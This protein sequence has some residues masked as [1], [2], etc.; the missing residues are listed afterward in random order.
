MINHGIDGN[1]LFLDSQD[2]AR[3]VHNLYEFNDTEQTENLHRLFDPKM[4]DLGG[5]SFRG[6]RRIGKDL[7]EI[8]GWCLM[9]THYHLLISELVEGG[10]AK[11]MMRVNVGYAKYYNE[12]YGRHGY[13]FRGKTK[14]V[15]VQNDAHFLYILH[16]IHLNPLDYLAGAKGWRERDKNAIKNAEEALQHLGE[17]RWSSYLDYCGKKNFPSLLTKDLFGDVSADYKQEVARY[18][19][20]TE[21]ALIDELVLE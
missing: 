20:D 14:K 1:K 10:L 21:L 11:F 15:L 7:V 8:H 6:K 5:R 18:L 19:K 13:V 2:Y 17:Y 16:Y 9:D 4:N 3:L 12:R